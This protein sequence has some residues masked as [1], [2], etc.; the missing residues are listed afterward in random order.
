MIDDLEKNLNKSLADKEI[1]S[2]MKTLAS[3]NYRES[4]SFP[5][6]VIQPF[7]P[8]SFF[9]V[10]TNNI[11]K[12][13]AKTPNEEQN[14]TP[15]EDNTKESQNHEEILE[16][17]SIKNENEI[18]EK[19]N[20][21][22][23]DFKTLNKSKMGET[24]ITSDDTENNNNL[25]ETKPETTNLE[26]P[27][28]NNIGI[29][30][31][32]NLFTK[33][34]LSNEY[35]KGYTEGIE[36]LNRKIS[37]EKESSIK[38][39]DNFIE[40]IKEKIFIDTK[41]LEKQIK[42]EIIKITSERVGLII[43]EMPEVFLEKI[44]SLANT[45]NKNTEKKIFKLNPEDLKSVER[46]IKDTASLNKFILLAD[47]SLSHGDCIIEIGEI[48]LEDKITDRYGSN[49]EA[50]RY[51]EMSSTKNINNNNAKQEIDLETTE[52]KNDP[53]NSNNEN[54]PEKTARTG[55][56][57]ENNEVKKDPIDKT[58]DLENKISEEST[59]T[60]E[61]NEEKIDQTKQDEI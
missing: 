28:T 1:A 18:I 38:N 40:E 12:N 14:I 10:A 24:D 7:K 36:E 49:E 29:P 25:I 45:I 52:I 5:K 17:E 46:I 9:E 43:N 11:N 26:E 22:K 32:E 3:K 50:T 51:F 34:E 35:Q 13:E 44:K 37:A 4:S 27:P 33:E 42:D 61:T 54:I 2:L 21:E 47:Q 48:S 8:I 39:F 56:D 16:D 23:E 41:V 60:N 53:I 57:L 20:S 6:K 59:D 58:I 19:T 30:V 15:T 31:K 55:T